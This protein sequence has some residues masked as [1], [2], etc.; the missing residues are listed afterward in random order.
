MLAAPAAAQY[1]DVLLPQGVLQVTVEDQPI[2]ATTAPVSPVTNPRIAGSL[3][4]GEITIEL[5][6]A[7]AAGAIIRFPSEVNR[8][9][10]FRQRVPEALQPGGEYTLYINDVM[11][12]QFTI[13]ADAVGGTGGAEGDVLEL[14]RL[15]PFPGD[16]AGAIAGLGL[17]PELSAY[18][19]IADLARVVA[20]NANNNNREG[21]E[22]A[23]TELAA[24]GF[25]QRYQSSLA[26]PAADDP[27]VFE[28][29][30][31]A[32]VTEYDTAE[33]A[34]ASF[35][36]SA[37]GGEAVES[38][39]VGDES[40]VSRQSAVATQTGAEYQS[41]Q[42]IFRQD[43]LLIV[44]NFADL[45][46]REPD[47][48]L[49]EAMGLAV[50][51]RGVA[52]LA[53][54]A[55]ALTRSSLRMNLDGIPRSSTEQLYGAI[56]GAMVPLFGESEDSLNT[57]ATAYTGAT[58]V[59]VSTFISRGT[60]ENETATAEGETAAPFSYVTTIL[61]F[62]SPEDASAWLGGLN[63]QSPAGLRP[64]FLSLS[65]VTDAPTF[66]EASVT[67]SF[68]QQLEG[69]TATGYL[70]YVQVGADIA[71]VELAAVPEAPFAAFEPLV[72][73]QA[74]CLTA[75]DCPALADP[76]ADLVAAG[77]NGQGGDDG[78]GG[79]DRQGQGGGDGQ[80]DDAEQTAPDD[81]PDQQGD[82]PSGIERESEAPDDNT[83]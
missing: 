5:A 3:T 18:Q 83:P 80:A 63:E 34:A 60:G 79:G 67:Y 39:L 66:G 68:T 73:G 59:S 49:L 4:S 44:I 56:D 74:E 33:T 78:Q 25:V 22:Q 81:A 41:L 20:E 43:R 6:V 58:D 2:N 77:G 27:S 50:Q 70:T 47:Q 40:R 54:E 75:G 42:L 65:A 24:S 23:E 17:V 14:A 11:I 26:V 10:G 8:R 37:T 29:Q 7:D 82:L 12:G 9:G 48:A 71:A 52:V 15:V 57:R 21:R 19:S 32:I 69:Q 28:I 61:R 31:A 13:A 76:P 55:P 62:P 46:N 16:A 35:A 45:L 1:A 53:G 64:E 36:A 38:P 72:T 51:Q 30:I